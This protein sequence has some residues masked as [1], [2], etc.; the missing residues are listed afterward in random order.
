MDHVRKSWR[1]VRVVLIPKPGREPS[2]AKY[3]LIAPGSR[4]LGDQNSEPQCG[5]NRNELTNEQ[6]LY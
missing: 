6:E 5:S 2:L 4:M 1:D 3:Y